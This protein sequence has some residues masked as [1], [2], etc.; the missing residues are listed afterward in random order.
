MRIFW[1][2]DLHGGSAHQCAH[3]KAAHVIVLAEIDSGSHLQA[4]FDGDIFQLGSLEFRDIFPDRILNTPD[5]AFR[6]SDTHQCRHEGFAHGVGGKQSIFIS[7]RKVLLI[8]DH[9]VLDDDHGRSLR[10]FHELFCGIGGSFKI[11]AVGQHSIV[12]LCKLKYVTS[13]ADFLCGLYL[14]GMLE[15]V[16][17]IFIFETVQGNVDCFYLSSKTDEDHACQNSDRADCDSDPFLFLH[18]IFSFSM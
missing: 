2:N 9:I 6:H 14:R 16:R 18:V 12:F 17:Q 4:G 1:R 8:L 7:T 3:R 15:C 10:V 11:K 5:T 13:L